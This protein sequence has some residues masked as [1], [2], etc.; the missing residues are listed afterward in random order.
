MLL[1]PK[2]KE[3]AMAGPKSQAGAGRN[4][5][6]GYEEQACQKEVGSLAESCPEKQQQGR[7]GL[8][9]PKLL[10][11]NNMQKAMAGPTH[12]AGAGRNASLGY[13]EQVCQKEPGNLAGSSPEKQQEGSSGG[14][15]S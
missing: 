9:A 12:R 4:A 2:K 5:S 15:G 3:V 13:K 6:P 14:H 1:L 11:P 7:G 8:C 10:P